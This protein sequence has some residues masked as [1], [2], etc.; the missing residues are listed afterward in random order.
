MANVTYTVKY[1]DTLSQIAAKH[2]TTV[3]AL[4]KLNNIANPNYIVVGQVLIISGSASSTKTN[5]SNK[6]IIQVFGLQSRTDRTVYATWSWD[7]SNTEEY[8]VKW[9]YATGDGVGFIGSESTVTHKQSVYTAPD[10]ATK[11]T[12]TV[13]PIAKK[14]EVNG[15]ETA[16]WTANWSTSKTYDF[17]NNPPKTPPVPAVEIVDGK[18]IAEVENLNVNAT[19]IQFQ[20][21]KNNGAVFATG[22]STIKTTFASYS[23]SVAAGGE[24]KVRCRS[25]KGS[26][27]S[28]WSEYSDNYSTE[29]APPAEITVLKALTET[30]VYVDWARVS[31]AETYDVEY[32]TQKRYF[33]SSSE[34]QS[35]SVESVVDH[36]EVTGLESGK[37]WFFR[38]RGVNKNGKSAWTKIESITLGV[39]PAAPTTWSS[40]STVIAGEP[41]N[42]YWVHNSEDGSS[43][44]YAE[45]ELIVNGK[46][47]TKLIK[48]S[49]DEDEKDKTSVYAFDTSGYSEGT[50][51]EWRVR[52]KGI[53]DTY[54]EWSIQRTVDVYSRPSVSIS[55]AD[56]SDN[57]VETLESFPFYVTAIAAPVS[58]TP[59]GFHISIKAKE[60]YATVDNIGNEVLVK[61]GQEL[62]SRYFDTNELSKKKFSASDVNLDNNIQYTLTVTVAMNSGLSAEASY[63][64]TVAWTDEEYSPDAEVGYDPDTLTT[65]IRPYCADEMGR[66]IDGVTLSVYR[67]E[68]DGAFTELGRD[69][70]NTKQTFITDPHPA[71]DYAR[72]RVVAVTESTGA[73]SFSDISGYPIG[74]H[75]VIIQWDEAW[76]TFDTA[77]TGPLE[78][79]AW[80]GSM[81]RLPYN[82]DVSDAYSSD[83]S[84]IEYIGRKRPVSYYGTQLGE[85]ATWRTE[86]PKYDKET[87]YGL[88]RL[89]AWMGDAYVREPSGS[90]YWARVKVSFNQQHK[91]LTIP[92]TLDITRV[93][94]GA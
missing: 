69:L 89:G 65:Y 79:P 27:Y 57:L 47:T 70:V 85:T 32:T 44:T 40:T 16:Y 5:T 11:V 56:S 12:F 38:V 80:T 94:G 66:L 78:Q 13:K 92:V 45:L 60:P 74:E 50:K 26:S 55:V 18:L 25:V 41:L 23:C 6:P 58:Q 3:N 33:D 84:L 15:K 34:V 68:F 48:N 21:V 93:E 73:I 88:R 9:T 36:A 91:Q 31:T 61:A 75:A 22:T 42:L 30:S 4:V 87:L 52:T 53:I 81:L 29:P 49:T 83:V 59:I 54:S 2:G 28:E 24:Y 64:F 7:K 63:D 71:L 86:I 39:A 51:L 14:R 72:Y 17:S 76:S 62:Y 8:Q 37:E 43:Q 82:I 1:G 19:Q 90:G 46:E 35:L 67:R 10:N 77:N 20:V